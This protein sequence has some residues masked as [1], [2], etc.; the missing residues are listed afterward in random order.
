MDERCFGLREQPLQHQ[1]YDG[2]PTSLFIFHFAVACYKHK[3][4]FCQVNL[5]IKTEIEMG[6]VFPQ[7]SIFCTWNEFY[8]GGG[9]VFNVRSMVSQ[10]NAAGLLADPWVATRD[11]L[12]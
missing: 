10:T 9:A 6:G 1:F 11:E 5:L 2:C 3:M 8:T 7:A 4:Y 12:P